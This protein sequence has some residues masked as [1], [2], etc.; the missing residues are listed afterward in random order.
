MEDLLHSID[1]E[2]LSDS[3]GNISDEKAKER[4]KNAIPSIDQG[5]DCNT[6]KHKEAK[7]LL[8]KTL[9]TI[10]TEKS[11]QD[12]SQTPT[13]NDASLTTKIVPDAKMKELEKRLT[14]ELTTFTGPQLLEWSKKKPDR[15]TPFLTKFVQNND[16]T[17]ERTD[18]EKTVKHLKDNIVN[19]IIT[20][21]TNYIGQKVINNIILGHRPSNLSQINITGQKHRYTNL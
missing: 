2:A 20:K 19:K 11:T 13:L 3:D 15:I 7:E 17:I 8:I 6:K 5:P 18:I 1:W 4:I 9:R 16:T 14:K 12:F 10:L 21:K